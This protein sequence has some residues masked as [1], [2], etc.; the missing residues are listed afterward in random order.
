[1]HGCLILKNMHKDGIK[2]SEDFLFTWTNVFAKNNSKKISRGHVVE[3]IHA[4][5]PSD[6]NLTQ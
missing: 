4:H 3:N 2:R 5:A 6:Y 1:M